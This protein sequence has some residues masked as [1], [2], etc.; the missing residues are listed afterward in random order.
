[1]HLFTFDDCLSY[2]GFIWFELLI[3]KQNFTMRS[4]VQPMAKYDS[5]IAI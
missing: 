3:S 1:M 2:S 4:Y 5:L